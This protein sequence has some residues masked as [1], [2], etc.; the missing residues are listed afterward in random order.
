MIARNDLVR[1]L[2]AIPLKELTSVVND[3]KQAFEVRPVSLSTSGLGM[4]KLKDSAFHEPFY[5]GEFPLVSAWL[6]VKSKTGETVQ[7]AAYVMDD[8]KELAEMLA[9]C[10]AVHSARLPG[11]ENVEQLALKGMSAIEKRHHER[12]QILAHTK[13]EFSLLDEV[14]DEDV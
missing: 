14:E 9:L 6:E 10:D 2:L 12:K 7:G 3:L 1:S 4:L 13:V 5:L 8:Q 11:Y